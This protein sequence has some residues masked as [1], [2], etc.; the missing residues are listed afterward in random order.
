VERSEW[1]D[2][3]Q[4]PA[5]PLPAHERAWRHPSEMGQGQRVQTEPPLALGRGLMVA[6]G[7]IGGLLAVAVLWAML[8]ASSDAPSAAATVSRLTTTREVVATT[9]S[10]A[11]VRSSLTTT[12][13]TS[14]P[15]STVGSSI[16]AT[17]APVRSTTTTT[18]P[19]ETVE[20]V[21]T[22]HMV[23][24]DA[25]DVANAVALAGTGMLLTTTQAVGAGD[26]VQVSMGD[27][28]IDADVVV[29][30]ATSGVAVLKPKGDS[31]AKAF[32]VAGC[33]PGDTVR[34]LGDTPF[35]ADLTAADSGH[36]SLAAA[37]DQW[38]REG[39]PVVD[40][41]GHLVGLYS[42][43]VRGREMLRVDRVMAGVA[44]TT[45][46]AVPDTSSTPAPSSS[47]AG[48]TSSVP[49]SASSATSTTLAGTTTPA[50]TSAVAPATTLRAMPVWLGVQADET[51]DGLT[52]TALADGGPAAAAG[53][54]VG[55]VITELAGVPVT[56]KVD[57]AAVL[58]ARAPG[59]TIA[60]TVLRAGVRQDLRAVLASRPSL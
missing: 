39:T 40:H 9:R 41:V 24:A 46:T 32:T 58:G 49:A 43:T 44:E 36:M 57:V 45:T 52:I 25:A 19:V 20:P 28:M 60:V 34:V 12:Q 2:D 1:D 7:A 31:G 37:A 55:D 56:H 38:A 5:A 30:D 27:R 35:D 50:G 16:A 17:L 51:A 33:S 4:Y 53:V 59:D 26:T 54:A 15:R 22:V 29:R 3:E 47:F 18:R 6:T 8:P 48:T 21:A 23:A 10:I 14:T 13:A 42:T 11:T